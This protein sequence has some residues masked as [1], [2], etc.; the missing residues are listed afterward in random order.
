[1]KEKTI[2]QR[3]DELRNIKSIQCMSGNYDYDPYMHG[4]AN[5]IILAEA[6]LA[7]IEPDFLVAP[8]QWLSKA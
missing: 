8:N 6:I 7:N 4:M 1:M 5:G 2:E 3:F